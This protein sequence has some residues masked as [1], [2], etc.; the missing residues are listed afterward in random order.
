MSLSLKMEEV[1][2][3]ADVTVSQNGKAGWTVAGRAHLH[4][5]LSTNAD[6]F[7]LQYNLGS[8]VA[9][10]QVANNV[11]AHHSQNKLRPVLTAVTDTATPSPNSCHRHSY[12]QSPQLSL[13][14]LHPV[15]TA[16]TDTAT[17]SPHSCHWHSYT[18][19]PQLSQTQLHPV[20]TATPSPHSCHRHS[21]T[22]SRQPSQTQLHPVPTAVTDAATPSPL[23]KP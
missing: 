4:L 6:A 20:L 10:C 19:S 12:T 8:F 17:P 1:R 14:Q 2:K 11:S 13:T 16:V 21:Y 15:P 23:H 22:Q 3:G 9:V 7:S 18:Q 5:Q